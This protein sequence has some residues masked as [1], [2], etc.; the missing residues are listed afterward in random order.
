MTKCYYN[1]LRYEEPLMCEQNA[2]VN[3]LPFFQGMPANGEHVVADVC[4]YARMPL[5]TFDDE[6]KAG[7][8]HDP[9]DTC[10]R[11]LRFSFF[12]TCPDI[13]ARSEVWE[14]VYEKIQTLILSDSDKTL[15]KPVEARMALQ[16][17]LNFIDLIPHLTI[18][19]YGEWYEYFY[20]LVYGWGTLVVAANKVSLATGR[21]RVFSPEYENPFFK[22]GNDMMGALVSFGEGAF[23][24]RSLL[25]QN[26]AVQVE[27]KKLC[28]QHGL[29]VE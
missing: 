13:S 17:L 15:R 22:R 23:Y 10:I 12:T 25:N 29:D 9:C 20:D 4:D 2:D 18:E 16:V 1:L 8:D 11:R 6:R 28:R 21:K 19:Q 27:V 26:P 7:Q 24:K 5:W 3:D 14:E